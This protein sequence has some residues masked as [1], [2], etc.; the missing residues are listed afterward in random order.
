MKY[1]EETGYFHKLTR[2]L[3]V[4]VGK[5]R[6]LDLYLPGIVIN[7]SPT[8][9]RVNRQLQMMRFNGERWE[10]FGPVI[11]SGGS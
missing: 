1:F 11:G 4:H 10:S 8:D 3:E 6:L 7:T 5:R 2:N 9:Y